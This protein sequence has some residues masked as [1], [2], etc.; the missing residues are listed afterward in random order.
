MPDTGWLFP[1]VTGT[2][3][4]A[5][6]AQY[7]TA[8]WFAFERI[9]AIDGQCTITSGLAGEK[10][11]N[12]VW[13]NW[14]RGEDLRPS[15]PT[16]AQITGLEIEV[17][18]RRTAGVVDFVSISLIR[19]G[20]YLAETRK[21]PTTRLAG[22]FQTLRFGGRTDMWGYGLTRAICGESRFGFALQCRSAASNSNVEIDYVRV[23]IHYNTSLSIQPPPAIEVE[24]ALDA[25]AIYLSVDAAPPAAVEVEAALDAMAILGDVT[26]TPPPAIEIEAALDPVG[27]RL[28]TYFSYPAP[29]AVE[30]EAALDATPIKS[31]VTI[32]GVPPAVEAEAASVAGDIWFS[33]VTALHVPPAIEIEAALPPAVRFI[34]TLPPPPPAI[35]IEAPLDAQVRLVW[36]AFRLYPDFARNSQQS[37]IRAYPILITITHPSAPGALRY[38]DAGVDLESRGH[39]FEA[40]GFELRLPSNGRNDLAEGEL[41][42]PIQSAKNRG[43][44][45]TLGPPRPTVLIEQVSGDDPDAVFHSWIM[46]IRQTQTGGGWITAALDDGDFETRSFPPEKYHANWTGVHD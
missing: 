37:V 23:K 11:A 9:R 21:N 27:V 13:T 30:I 45:R 43:Y 4:G 1:V 16:G 20:E 18:L 25:P 36:D 35:E 12:G 32:T 22:T 2:H 19:A 44:L 6:N 28:S 46:E 10:M 34:T 15:I 31:S 5:W 39:L 41:S 38:T 17:Y 33:S 7:G 8:P 42:L 29:P 14:L 40:Q 24:R 26:A 3:S